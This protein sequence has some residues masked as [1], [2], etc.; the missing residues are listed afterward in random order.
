MCRASLRGSLEH[1]SVQI[2]DLTCQPMGALWQIKS[3]KFSITV[4]EIVLLGVWFRKNI[5]VNIFC[6]NFQFTTSTKKIK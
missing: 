1:W 2:G 4:V 3:S 5:R 6:S